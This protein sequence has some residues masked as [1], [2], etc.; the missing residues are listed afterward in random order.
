MVDRR[1]TDAARELFDLHQKEIHKMA[2]P[3]DKVPWMKACANCEFSSNVPN[4]ITL[5][6]RRY[7]PTDGSPVGVAVNWW[8]GEFKLSHLLKGPA[9]VSRFGGTP[10]RSSHRSAV[11]R[12][13]RK[14]I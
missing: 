13:N 8:C 1:I 11:R 7:P 9:D 2:T 12:A 10:K 6:C 14:G 5:I 4:H 3:I